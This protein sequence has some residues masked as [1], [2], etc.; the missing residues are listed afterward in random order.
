ML[1]AASTDKG[2]K[3]LMMCNFDDLKKFVL[4][5]KLATLFVVKTSKDIDAELK[6][7]IRLTIK[8]LEEIGVNRNEL[9]KG[10]IK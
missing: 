7:Q 8:E 4:M 2:Y 1:P 3:I 6:A 9:L 10:A 5:N